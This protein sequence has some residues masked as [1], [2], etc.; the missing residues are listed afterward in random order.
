MGLHR[1]GARLDLHLKTLPWLLCEEY[2]NPDGKLLQ[3]PRG[4]RVVSWD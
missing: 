1:E 4:V 2:R 3:Q